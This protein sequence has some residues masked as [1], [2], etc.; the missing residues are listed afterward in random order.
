MNY[1]VGVHLLNTSHY[2]HDFIYFFEHLSHQ[3]KYP[4][5]QVRKGSSER[6]CTSP[7][8]HSE[9]V[10]VASLEPPRPSKSLSL[11]S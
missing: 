6:F 2:V 8:S 11:L 9:E 5:L 7:G 10:T 3:D 4:H 1:F